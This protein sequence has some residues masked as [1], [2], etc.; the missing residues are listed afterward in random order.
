MVACGGFHLTKWNSNCRK[1]LDD[2]PCDEQSKNLNTI[3]V[4]KDTLPIERTLGMEWDID[5]DSFRFKINVK[6]KPITRR[7]MLS[8]IS[9]V[10]DH[11]GFVAPF[12]LPAKVLLQ[13][14]ELVN[15]RD[16]FSSHP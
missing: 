13:T 14:V 2:I 12:I 8:I 11:L 9:S 15:Y 6:K 5:K 7:G 10:F 16:N 1:V 3:N 4:Q